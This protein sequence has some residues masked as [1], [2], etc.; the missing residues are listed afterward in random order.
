[1]KEVFRPLFNEAAKVDEINETGMNI[2]YGVGG[3]KVI[4]KMMQLFHDILL[5]IVPVFGL[6]FTRVIVEDVRIGL[7]AMLEYSEVF[8]SCVVLIGCY[9]NLFVVISVI[10]CD[11]GL[12]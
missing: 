10:A 9:C 7:V 5:N 6:V 8:D 11:V 4:V 3:L 2:G 12:D 1:M